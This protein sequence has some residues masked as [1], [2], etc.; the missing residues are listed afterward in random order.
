MFE[1]DDEDGF[2]L[3]GAGVC[4]RLNS[5]EI[6]RKDFTMRDGRATELVVTS[7]RVA[8]DE[9]A[10]A[11]EVFHQSSDQWTDSRYLLELSERPDYQV[12]F[13]PPA[14]VE[15]LLGLLVEESR[16]AR[17]FEAIWSAC[18]VGDLSKL[19]EYLA[20]GGDIDVTNV[21]DGVTLL[22]LACVEDD[23]DLIRALVIRGA[24]LNRRSGGWPLLHSTLDGEIDGVAQTN[25]HAQA[26]DYELK[27]SRLLV[28]LGADMGVRDERG[29]T[30]R[31]F[32]LHCYPGLLPV[33]DSYFS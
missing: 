29:W 3:L 19:D 27:T 14:M 21:K 13:A 23:H 33:F 20:Q 11:L 1:D 9:L 30:A 8:P 2:R 12:G 16:H 22:G 7:R 6:V 5:E 4:V 15:L 32:I 17:T 25:Y 10:R 24:D 31:E 26:C 28:A 18:T